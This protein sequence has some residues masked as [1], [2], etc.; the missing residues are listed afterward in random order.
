MMELQFF[1]SPDFRPYGDDTT[2][3]LRLTVSADEREATIDRL[4]EAGWGLASVREL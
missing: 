1:D 4:L 3:E 2:A